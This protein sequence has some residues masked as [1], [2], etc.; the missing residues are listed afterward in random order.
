MEM[1]GANHVGSII[2][3]QASE[4]W[5]WGR[6]A[7]GGQACLVRCVPELVMHWCLLTLLQSLVSPWQR[8]LSEH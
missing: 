2:N 4:E 5:E 8:A 1:D 3:E 7:G 6:R